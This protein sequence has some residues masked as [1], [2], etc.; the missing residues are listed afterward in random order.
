MYGIMTPKVTEKTLYDNRERAMV[1]LRRREL[2]MIIIAGSQPGKT[3]G[4]GY[5]Q[6]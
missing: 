1:L 5:L 3:L 4:V 6:A 2:E